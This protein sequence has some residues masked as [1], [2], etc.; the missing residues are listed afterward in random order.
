MFHPA[1]GQFYSSSLFG[2]GQYHIYPSRDSVLEQQELLPFECENSVSIAPY[3]A[4]FLPWSVVNAVRETPAMVAGVTDRLW[5][6]GDIIHLLE[7]KE[8]Q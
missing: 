5:E 1:A 4:L 2:T 7:S 3:S 6:I 8:L